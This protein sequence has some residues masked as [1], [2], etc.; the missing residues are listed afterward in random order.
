MAASPSEAIKCSGFGVERKRGPVRQESSHDQNICVAH[1]H[2][3]QIPSMFKIACSF[4]KK[5]SLQKM[6]LGFVENC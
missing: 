4:A 3:G 1:V 2:G 6:V 5:L